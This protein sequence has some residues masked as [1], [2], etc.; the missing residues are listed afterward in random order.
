MELKR[1][2]QQ[3]RVLVVL[4]RPEFSSQHPRQATQVPTA[5]YLEHV[6]SSAGLL[7]RLYLKTHSLTHMHVL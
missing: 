5:L 7:G 3:L 4:R 1:L 6:M 2:A